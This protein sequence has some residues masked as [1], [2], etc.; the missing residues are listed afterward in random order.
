MSR[1]TSKSENYL[2]DCKLLFCEWNLIGVF[3]SVLP[4]VYARLF[5]VGIPL[6]ANV[7]QPWGV[8]LTREDTSSFE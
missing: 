5:A 3:C 2:P 8:V 4:P 7:T 6:L 1:N